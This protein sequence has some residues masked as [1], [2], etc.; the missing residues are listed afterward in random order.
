MERILACVDLSPVSD[1]VVQQAARL[2]SRIDVELVVLHVAPAEPE[3]VGYGPGPQPVRDAVARDLRGAH[4]AT[5]RLA[6]ALRDGGLDAVKALTI[7]GSAPETI[8]AQAEALDAAFVVIGAHHRGRIH[9]LFVGSVAREVLRRT[10]RP[11]LVVP[12]RRGSER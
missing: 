2:A 1:R 11:V 5:Q 9:E 4:D 12:A 6:G 10:T 8:L 3:W 7:Q